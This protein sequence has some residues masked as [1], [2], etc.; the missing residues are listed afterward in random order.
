MLLFSHDTFILAKRLS[1]SLT[2]LVVVAGTVLCSEASRAAL[3][4]SCPC[5]VSPQSS[6]FG[7]LWEGKKRHTFTMNVRCAFSKGMQICSWLSQRPCRPQTA[8]ALESL[9]PVLRIFVHPFSSFE[10]DPERINLWADIYFYSQR[11]MRKAERTPH[12]EISGEGRKGKL[13]H[14][15]CP[16]GNKRRNLRGQTCS[17]SSQPHLL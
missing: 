11:S 8:A 5:S 4:S 12:C 3:G 1:P 6:L 2:H 9:W 16:H 15:I 14:P 13:C 10:M 17:S 7:D